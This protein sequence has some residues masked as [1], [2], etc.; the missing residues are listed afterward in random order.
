[1]KEVMCLSSRE[2]S[3]TFLSF[4]VPAVWI[5][6]PRGK[7]LKKYRNLNTWTTFALEPK[8]SHNIRDRDSW[9]L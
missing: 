5:S 8:Q 7:S 2:L 3:A 9:T 1:M 6:S 4:L